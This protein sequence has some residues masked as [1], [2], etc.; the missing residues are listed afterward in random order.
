MKK[1][2]LSLLIVSLSIGMSFASQYE[3]AMTGAIQK[4]YQATDLQGYM[5]AI[6]TFERIGA[7]ENEEWLPQYY[8]GLGYI[9]A[10]HTTQDGQQIDAL[11][12]KA[13]VFVDEAKK[14]SPENDEILTLQGYIYMMKVV[15]DPSGRGPQLSGAALQS[16][17]QAVSI[18][19]SNPR[20]LLFL[21]RMQMGTDQFFGNDTSESCDMI[22]KA[23]QM[24]EEQQPKSALDPAWGKQMAEGF[25]NECRAD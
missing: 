11:L 7:R 25:V 20:A 19:E 10:S 1:Y 12:D 4:L 5:D 23:N 15:V 8:A 21:G 3:Q 6:A 2:I 18:N 13:Q 14:L 24:L 16:F 22:M 9:W 17:G